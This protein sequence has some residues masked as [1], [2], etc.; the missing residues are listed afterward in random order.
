M[1]NFPF[2]SIAIP[3]RNE[4]RYISQCLESLC[5]QDYPKDRFEILIID[6]MSEDRTIDRIRDFIKILNIRILENPRKIV[7]CALNIGIKEARGD[8]IIRMDAHTGYAPDYISK[9]IKW[10][11]K[12]GADNVGGPIISLPG[13]NSIIS[14][15][16]ALASS[17]IFGVGNSKFRTSNKAGYV[18]TITFGAW[19]KRIF[20][21]VGLFNE[22]LARNQD[23]EFNA[24][25]RKAGGKIY[26]TPEIKSYYHCR[27][28]LKDIWR[29]NFN[30]GKWVI[31]TKAIAPYS[32][33]W[34]H[35]V[36]FVFVSSIFIFSL[37]SFY[38]TLSVMFLIATAVSYTSTNLLFSLSVTFNNGF[39]YFLILPLIFFVFHLSYG[40]G[41]IWGL[42]RLGLNLKNVINHRGIIFSL[43]SRIG[44]GLK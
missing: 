30:N 5:H 36:P 15:A 25:I 19:P 13:N 37:L 4:E 20:E 42:I 22:S 23:I 3:V 12:T 44:Y 17:S 24:R 38:S 9:C 29:Q 2:V 10:L 14:K 28:T 43:K 16:I 35:F 26:M 8:Y 1:N 41:S 21:R 7:P 32:L 33:S 11:I 31:Y 34:R 40:L 27:S 18:D 39:R 6:G